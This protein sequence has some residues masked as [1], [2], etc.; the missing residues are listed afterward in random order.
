MSELQAQNGGPKV[1][2][3]TVLNESGEAAVKYGLVQWQ[4]MSQER[5]SLRERVHQLEADL[6]GYKVVVEAQTSQLAHA[7]SKV[8]EMA[9]VRDQAI[10]RA[11]KWEVLWR[12]VKA[13]LN[14]FQIPSEPYISDGEDERPEAQ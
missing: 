8:A 13:Q 5:D 11:I 7:D 3:T 9:L 2:R 12:S 4:A 10:A 1:A 14:A 6:A